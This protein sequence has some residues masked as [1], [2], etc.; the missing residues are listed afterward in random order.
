MPAGAG[1]DGRDPNNGRFTTGNRCGQGNPIH[2]RIAALRDRLVYALEQDVDAVAR[3]LLEL[4]VGGDVCAARLVLERG[5]G[6][7]RQEPAA[8]PR[9]DVGAIDSLAAISTAS[10]RIVDLVASCEV[11]ADQGQTLLGILA[12]HRATLE[13]CAVEDLEARLARLERGAP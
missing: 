8:G 10:A 2:K 12:Q 1:D 9:I 7:T 5:L 6:S 11:D 3:K 13:A 4:A